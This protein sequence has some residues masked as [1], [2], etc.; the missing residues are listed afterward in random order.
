MKYAFTNILSS[1][2]MFILYDNLLFYIVLCTLFTCSFILVFQFCV[3]K[4]VRIIN[5]EYC[6]HQSCQ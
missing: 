2:N 5:L 6:L 4:R 1:S 3:I